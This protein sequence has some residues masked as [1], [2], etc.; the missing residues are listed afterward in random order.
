[1]SPK[2]AF[3]IASY[4]FLSVMFYVWQ[5]TQ[6]TRLSYQVSELKAQCEKINEENNSLQLKISSQLSLEKLDEVAKKKGLSVPD[7]RKVIYLDEK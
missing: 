3:I 7:E 1:M 6:N 4:L 5:R 2:Y